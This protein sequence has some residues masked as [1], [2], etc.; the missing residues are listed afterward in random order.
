M[1]IVQTTCP[2]SIG[3]LLL[4]SNWSPKTSN[5]WLGLDLTR[6]APRKTWYRTRSRSSDW[7]LK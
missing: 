2:L 6:V 7:E 4:A 3:E 5:H 1:E